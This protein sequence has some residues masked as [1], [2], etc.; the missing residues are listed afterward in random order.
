MPFWITSG[1]NLTF[2]PTSHFFGF[3][4]F[5]SLVFLIKISSDYERGVYALIWWKTKRKSR[6]NTQRYWTKQWLFDQNLFT[7]TNLINESALVT[8]TY[9]LCMDEE[10][11]LELLSLKMRAAISPHER[12]TVTLR[13]IATG[14]YYEDLQL[15]TCTSPKALG[16]IIPET[17]LVIC[18]CLVK[19]YLKRELAHHMGVFFP[20][21]K[22]QE[23]KSLT[24]INLVLDW[25]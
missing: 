17:C 3:H 16:N 4:S 10:T 22:I 20:L 21:R 24:C 2:V 19:D 15:S 18:K 8:F 1:V 6:A 12:L 9:Y 7:H 13:F 25:W 14:R 11:Y 5:S 23:T